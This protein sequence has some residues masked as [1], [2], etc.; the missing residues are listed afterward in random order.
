VSQN[1]SLVLGCI[2][3]T[4][5]CTTYTS[6]GIGTATPTYALDVQTSSTGY[7]AINI[8]N[9]TAGTAAAAAFQLGNDTNAAGAGLLLGS[10]TYATL[11]GANSLNLINNDAG[12]LTLGT[13]G[14]VK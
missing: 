5:G 8:L 4:N 3:G 11:G 6:V 1:N 12:P 7:Q 14:T 9:S 13:S 2:A 10:S